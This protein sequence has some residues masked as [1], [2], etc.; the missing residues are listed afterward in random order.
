MF[1]PVLFQWLPSDWE[2]LSHACLTIQSDVL[3]GFIHVKEMIKSSNGMKIFIYIIFADILSIIA[4][5]IED[6][7]CIGMNFLSDKPRHSHSLTCLHEGACFGS[8]NQL[9]ISS[10][11]TMILP[12]GLVESSKLEMSEILITT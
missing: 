4:P 6:W 5:E 9:R 8:V 12:D 3:L 7:M 1:C 11:S 2:D 10:L